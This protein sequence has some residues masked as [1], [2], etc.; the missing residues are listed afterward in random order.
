MAADKKGGVWEKPL[1][2]VMEDYLEAIYELHSDE[3]IK[4]IRVRDIAKKLD[5]KMPTVTSMLKVLNDRDLVNYEKYEYLELTDKGK[6]IGREMKKRHHII[7]KFLTSVLNIDM[8]TADE[9]A[10][11]MEHALG[12][13]TMESLTAFMEFIQVCPRAGDD[14]VAH[15]QAYQ[16]H[17]RRPEACKEKFEHFK[18][19]TAGESA[20]S[21]KCCMEEK[22]NLSQ[23]KEGQKGRII[24]VGG[25]IRL[26][27]R[28]IEMGLSRGVYFRVEKYAPL[29]DPL[30]LNVNGNHV[31]LRVKEAAGIIVEPGDG[32]G[33]SN[34]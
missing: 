18:C 25:E 16:Q 20:I 12:S 19:E 10:C 4:A 21:G 33:V 11:K 32:K 22:M 7:R 17:G 28:I 30:E 13:S 3:D 31:S 29:K 6:G 1:T 34:E 2:P 27:R 9:E 5:V 14:W 24:S 15:F 23:M 26:R 8:K